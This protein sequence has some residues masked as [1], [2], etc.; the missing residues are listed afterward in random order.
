MVKRG[1]ASA[2]NGPRN[3]AAPIARRVYVRWPLDLPPG[4]ANARCTIRRRPEPADPAAVSR[5]GVRD[6]YEAPAAD[7]VRPMAELDDPRCT[8]SGSRSTSRSSAA[9]APR[10]ARPGSGAAS[11]PVSPTEPGLDIDLATSPGIADVGD[12]ESAH[13]SVEGT[14]DRVSAVVAALVGTGTPLVCI[15]GD[16]GLAFPI[17]RGVSQALTG[18]RI[19][20]ISV[21]AHFDVRISHHG[22]P[23]TGVPFRWILERHPEAF[24]GRNL[25]EFGL[26]GSLNTKLY[27]DY[28]VE[29][30]ARLVTLRGAPPPRLGHGRAG[31]VRP[32]CRR[33]RRD[34]DDVRHRRHRGLD[35]DGHERAARSA[36]CRRSRPRTWCTRSRSTR[37]RRPRHHGGVAAAEPDRPTERQAASLMLDFAAGRHLLRPY[38]AEFVRRPAQTPKLVSRTPQSKDRSSL[39][40]RWCG[41]AA[42]F[43]KPPV[44]ASHAENGETRLVTIATIGR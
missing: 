15:G 43:P 37:S 11:S 41:A 7:I 27:H 39:C 9:A 31:G 8:C 34:L 26:A 6:P 29:Q 14:W 35:R 23:S 10:R 12:V 28:L 44:T 20:V 21:D 42:V 40:D 38:C 3:T 22:A 2:R 30:G 32:R 19:G 4:G 24:S 1:D 16:H 18:K 5:P 25:V 36:D 13:T 33:H 17:L